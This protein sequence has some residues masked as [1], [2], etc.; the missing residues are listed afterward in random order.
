MCGGGSAIIHD[1]LSD[2]LFG[3]PGQWSVRRCTTAGCGLGWV[4]PKPLADQIGKLYEGYYTHQAG[5]EGG[6]RYVTT[7]IKRFAKRALATVFF[8]KSAAYRTDYFHL[9]GMNPGRLLEIGCG[10]GDFLRAAAAAGWDALGIDFDAEAVEAARH[11][12]G[13][14][15]SV[16]D[17]FQHAFP[18]ASFDAIVMNNLIE[19]VPDPLAEIREC[20]RLLRPGG[21]LVVITPNMDSMGHAVFGPDWRGLEPPRHLHLFSVP[22]LRRAARTA[23]YRRVTAFTTPGGDACRGMMRGSIEIAEK[24]G[25]PHRGKPAEIVRRERLMVTLG[26]PCG[27]WAV[28]VATA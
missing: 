26:R 20:R 14:R 5:G 21:R 15:A 12:P 6:Q 2:Q 25:R 16:G 17:L 8:W 19:H 24:C 28:L 3:A 18:D 27:E 23:G 7:G 11:H 4:D 10:N 1:T 9:E 13:V 22:T